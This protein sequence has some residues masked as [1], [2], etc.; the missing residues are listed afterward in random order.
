MQKTVT[1]Q[2]DRKVKPDPVIVETLT[3]D[4]ILAL[5][6]GQHVAVI[7]N[8]GKLGQVKINGA[9]KTWKRDAD[10]VEVPIKYGMY[11][12]ATFSLAQALDR[13]VREV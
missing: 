1:R 9:V 13:F 6:Y 4:E 2:S 12:C 8:N 11:E 5:H 10:R 3:K 7:L